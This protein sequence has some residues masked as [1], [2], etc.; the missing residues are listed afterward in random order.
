MFAPAVRAVCREEVRIVAAL[1]H[2]Q[3]EPPDRLGGGGGGGERRLHAA[4]EGLGLAGDV[5]EAIRALAV[6]RTVVRAGVEVDG[7]R[8]EPERAP[9]PREHGG[10]RGLLGRREVEDAA[11]QEVG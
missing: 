5:V 7:A 8:V 11:E 9:P 3:G 2:V 4:V 1:V 6:V 10:G